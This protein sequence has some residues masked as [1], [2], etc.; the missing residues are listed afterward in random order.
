[1]RDAK[2]ASLLADQLAAEG[3]AD[4]P[5]DDKDK[6]AK[7]KGDKEEEKK[8]QKA[9]KDGKSKVSFTLHDH[10]GDDMGDDDMV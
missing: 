9:P 7:G 5:K 2:A 3:G 10:M 1:V 6:G 8:E 4:A